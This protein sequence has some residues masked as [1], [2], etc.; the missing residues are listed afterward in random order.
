MISFR[1]DLKNE[2]EENKRLKA[3]LSTAIKEVINAAQVKEVYKKG[4]LF[5]IRQ[6]KNTIKDLKDTNENLTAEKKH[7]HDTLRKEIHA[8]AKQNLDK[9]NELQAPNDYAEALNIDIEGSKYENGEQ[10]DHILDL[11]MR[12]EEVESRFEGSWES[13]SSTFSNPENPP[14]SPAAADNTNDDDDEFAL[15]TPLERELNI[16]I[17]EQ[18]Q[19]I[20]H[21]RFEISSW[22]HNVTGT[23]KAW[24]SQV[25]ELR[26]VIAARDMQT[27]GR[28]SQIRELESESQELAERVMEL[29]EELQDHEAL[30]GEERSEEELL[31]RELLREIGG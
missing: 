13:G 3:E 19:E 15:S 4:S 31:G 14:N 27:Q 9:D 12:L 25:E 26:G 24:S 16:T 30:L 28:E 6:L 10:H 23:I 5:I 18:T 1:K 2:D 17:A 11:E 22:Q 20:E 21:L 8:L 29:M 7:V